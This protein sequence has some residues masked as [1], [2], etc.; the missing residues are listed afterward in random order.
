[1]KKRCPKCGE[2]KSADC[3]HVR[4]SRCKLCRKTF[5]KKPPEKSKE[6]YISN[7][8][9]IL[10][11]AKQYRKDNPDKL[12]IAGAT[13]RK[14]QD[15]NKQKNYMRNYSRNRKHTDSLFKLKA[16]ISYQ[17]YYGLVPLL[18]SICHPLI[19]FMFLTF[20]RWMPHNSLDLKYSRSNQSS[21][22]FLRFR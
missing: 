22:Q 19:I 12:R 10:D 17:I 5:N 18:A 2:E 3:F 9:S 4:Q 14:K 7:R 6:Y 20:A 21:F 15:K 1:M 8:G 13:Y 16:L 11:Y